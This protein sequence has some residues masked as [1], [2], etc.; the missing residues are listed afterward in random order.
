MNSNVGTFS[1]PIVT[2]NGKGLVTG[3]SNGTDC[4][5]TLDYNGTPQTQR[6][7]F[8]FIPGSNVTLTVGQL[9]AQI[10]G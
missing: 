8:N 5:Q 6:P 10:D 2:V 7:T 9:R 4:Y 3:I 1:N